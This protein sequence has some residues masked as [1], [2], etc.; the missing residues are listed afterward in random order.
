MGWW[1]GIPNSALTSWWQ[2]SHIFSMSA[3]L[4]VRAGPMCTL[5]H[6]QQETSEMACTPAFELWRLIFTDEVWTLRHIRHCVGPGG[7]L[8]SIRVVYSQGGCFPFL[9]SSSTLA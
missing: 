5:W 8:R 4:T 9:A 3:L 1:L 6:S 2:R 7:S